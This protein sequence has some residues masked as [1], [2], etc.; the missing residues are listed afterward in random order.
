MVNFYIHRIKNNKMTLEEVPQKWRTKVE[1]K[2]NN[3]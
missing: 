1:E 2:L 3:E